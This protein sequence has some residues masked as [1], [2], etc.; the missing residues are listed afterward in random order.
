MDLLQCGSSLVPI[1]P[2][3]LCPTPIPK[4]TWPTSEHQHL[5][6][7][8]TGVR[9]GI[10]PALSIVWGALQSRQVALGKL[11]ANVLLTH[12]LLLFAQ[13]GLVFHVTILGSSLTLVSVPSLT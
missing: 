1:V 13:P 8:C 3:D 11:L 6:A 9:Q 4:L 7:S 10:R 5:V 2:C 12:L